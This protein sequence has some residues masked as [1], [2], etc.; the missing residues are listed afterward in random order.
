M[1]PPAT[2][3]V[4]PHLYRVILD[5]D[6]LLGD[7]SQCGHTA[8]GRLVIER[9]WVG[10]DSFKPEHLCHPSR[11]ARCSAHAAP[12]DLIVKCRECGRLWRATKRHHGPL[13]AVCGCGWECLNPPP[14]RPAAGYNPAS[15]GTHP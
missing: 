1:K 6:G 2:V 13:H 4:G 12:D 3:S 5:D 11:L 14:C 15:V 9:R 8:A 7:N 10:L